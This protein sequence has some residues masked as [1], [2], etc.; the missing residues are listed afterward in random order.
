[1]AKRKVSALSSSSAA[2]PEDWRRCRAE[3]NVTSVK[4]AYT[5]RLGPGALVNLN[6][7][8]YSGERLRKLIPDDCL[9][10]PEPK[11]EQEKIPEPEPEIDEESDHGA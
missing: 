1:M 3:V 9:D 6:E 10:P 5:K 8:A 4:H 7:V 2:E 11:Q